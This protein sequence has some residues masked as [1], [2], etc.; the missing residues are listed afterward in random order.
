MGRR[1][2]LRCRILFHLRP[3]PQES[4][5]KLPPL[6]LE[7]MSAAATVNRLPPALSLGT[8]KTTAG[9]LKFEWDPG[10]LA[11][12]SEKSCTVCLGSGLRNRRNFRFGRASE[13]W[14]E[15]C[16]CSL[17]AIFQICY[18]KFQQI[19]ARPKH[20]S[21]TSLTCARKANRTRSF[22]RPS[23]EYCADFCLTA[24]RVLSAAQ[25]IVF[26][27]YFLEGHEWK[28]CAAALDLNQGTFFRCVYQVQERLGQAFGAMRPHRLYRINEYF[29]G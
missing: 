8:S 7:T 29:S 5:K 10:E 18:S 11:S 25:Y 17:R 12:L 9:R 21:R 16:G 22:G 24:R 28:Q 4:S 1:R 13:C 19:E 23:E 6:S 27:L 20:L 15:P 3:P 26:R 14:T 2:R